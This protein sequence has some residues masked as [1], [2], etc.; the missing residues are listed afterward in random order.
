MF[1]PMFEIS[2]MGDPWEYWSVHAPADR[3]R[4]TIIQNSR[5]GIGDVT[6]LAL[7]YKKCEYL[8]T[9]LKR[10]SRHTLHLHNGD[11][12][13]ETTCLI[14]STGLLGDWEVDRL[15]KMKEVV[16]SFCAGDYRRVIQIDPTGMNAANFTTFSTGIGTW[17]NMIQMKYIHDFPKEYNRVVGM[18]L[19]QQLPRNKGDEK[20]DKPSYVVDVKFA[21]VGGIVLSGMCPKL[22]EMD[23]PSGPYK[24]ELY[25]RCH[26]TDR[27]LK[28]ATAD[29]D[30]YQKAWKDEGSTHEYVPYPYTRAMIEEYFGWYNEVFQSQGFSISAD[31]PDALRTNPS[32]LPPKE[33]EEVATVEK[34]TD[35][36]TRIGVENYIQQT[37]MQWWKE[38]G[39]KQNTMFANIQ[40]V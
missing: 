29:W 11:R 3:S 17:G 38:S 25:H 40:Q 39:P 31:G 13:E 18:G 34:G 26:G 23:A 2:G 32:G 19:L 10:C 4:A 6:F 9:T 36:Q 35:E 30:K 14:K 5:F 37:H 7:I 1:K 22:Q 21:M 20:L 16:G 12:L 8:E 24:Y 33:S 28:D 15:H 27:C